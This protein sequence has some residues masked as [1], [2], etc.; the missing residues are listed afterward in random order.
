ML[1]SEQDGIDRDT[2]AFIRD[3]TIYV[4]VTAGYLE[5]G[6]PNSATGGELVHP[7]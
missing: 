4:I 2:T 5:L 1:S 7:K 6:H 3:T